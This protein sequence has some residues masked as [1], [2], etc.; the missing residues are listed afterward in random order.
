M[1][2]LESLNCFQSSIE[3]FVVALDEVRGFGTAVVMEM[4]RSHIAGQQIAVVEDVLQCSDL[5]WIIIVSWCSPAD[6]PL[7]IRLAKVRQIEDFRFQILH[8]RSVGFITSHLERLSDIFQEV[9]MAEL[10][11]HL[12]VDCSG[13]HAN[14]FIVIADESKELVAGVLELREELQKGLVVL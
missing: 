9:H 14:R 4:L 6:V 2:T 10:N 1:E 12:R 7:E 3:L 13:C 5:L 11:N 8:E